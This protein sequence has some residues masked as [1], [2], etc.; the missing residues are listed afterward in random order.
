MDARSF[1]RIRAIRSV[2]L[3]DIK[4]RKNP[5]I[6]KVYKLKRCKCNELW[7]T[8]EIAIGLGILINK[9]KYIDKNY[10]VATRFGESNGNKIANIT[11]FG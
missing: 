10:I 6:Y 2:N 1:P 9:M 8:S 7:R 5:F 3:M 11:L 4:I